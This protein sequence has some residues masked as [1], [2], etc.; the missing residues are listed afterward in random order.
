MAKNFLNNKIYV[1]LQLLLNI[2]I[3]KLYYF[4]ITAVN[5]EEFIY[6]L[7]DKLAQK[8]LLIQLI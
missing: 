5:N 7:V 8:E 2:T 4:L 6:N 3:T 1:N